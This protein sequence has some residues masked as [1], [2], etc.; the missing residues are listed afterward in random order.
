MKQFLLVFIGGGAGSMLRYALALVMNKPGQF[1]PWGTFL[2]NVVGCLLIGVVFGMA[3][4]GNLLN[5]NQTLLLATGFCGGFT[6]FSA[7]A[8]EKHAFLKNGDLANLA[9]YAIGSIVLGIA[10]VYI[11]LSLTK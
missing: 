4:K 10:A 5:S 3:E 9:I 2:A 1:L 8:F 11:G 7:F 6:T